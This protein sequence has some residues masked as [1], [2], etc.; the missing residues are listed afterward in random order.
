MQDTLLI[1]DLNPEQ[2][3]AVTH[4]TGSM[5]ILA[6]AGTGKTRTLT[7]R[8]AYLIAEKKVNASN[9]LAV[10][11]T[12]KAA[13]EMK[14]RIE[15]LLE[16][17]TDSWKIPMVG[18]FH[19]VSA[20]ILRDHIGKL[21]YDSSFSILDTDDQLSVIKGI[22]KELIIDPKKNNPKSV[23]ARISSA[24]NQLIR[25]ENFESSSQDP[26]GSIAQDVYP[27]YQKKLKDSN[28]VDFDDLIMLTVQLFQTHSEVLEYYQN[29]WRFIHVDEYQDTNYAQYIWVKTLAE[30]YQN[31]CVVGDDWQGIYSWRGADIKNILDFQKDYPETTVIKLEQNYR[32]TQNILDAAEAIIKKNMM[33]TDKKLWTDKKEGELLQVHETSSEKHEA[34]IIMTSIQEKLNQSRINNLSEAV[35]LYR[36]NAQSRALEEACLRFNVSY[37]I[38][39]GVKFYERM[40][41]K[42]MLAYLNLINNPRNEISLARVINVPTRGIGDTTWI[43][44]QQYAQQNNENVWNTLAL[45]TPDLSP[46]TNQSIREFVYLIQSL[47]TYSK[48]NTVSRLIEEIV[49]RSG[50]AKS[51]DDGTEESANRMENIRELLSVSQKYDHLEP[52]ASLTSFLE[53]VSLIADADA[54]LGGAKLTLMTIHAAKGLEFPIVYI[55]G[56]EENV[57]PHSRVQFSQEELEE[58]RRLAY[59]A[60]TRAKTECHLSYATSRMIYGNSQFNKASRFLSEIPE[61][62]LAGTKAKSSG[63]SYFSEPQYNTEESQEYTSF[64]V[65]ELVHHPSFGKGKIK[66]IRGDLLT[67]QF[68]IG[69]KTLAASIAPLRKV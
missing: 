68:S 13:S 19:S 67:I 7:H 10:T 16:E 27:R 69:E 59:V 35:V 6:G 5:L 24:K 37:Q 44:L 48:S 14:Q 12:N 36:T 11:F 66:A 2:Q 45:N 30:A 25:S 56:L 32:S 4:T 26:I 39:G 29:L 41:I 53:E 17:Y 22:Y 21:G 46:R 51:L 1:Q 28:S 65:G 63:I 9:I 62:L 34:N 57:F 18:T 23:L 52:G 43:K 40:E 58:E 54:D 42:D 50:Y 60:I 20:R 31:I 15:K 55:A 64:I 38:I 47:Q 33:R 3:R 61:H 8:I 49:E